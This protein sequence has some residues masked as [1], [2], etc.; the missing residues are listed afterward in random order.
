MFFIFLSLISLSSFGLS[1]KSNDIILSKNIKNQSARK[2]HETFEKLEKTHSNSTPTLWRLKFQKSLFLKKKEQKTFCKN[3]KELSKIESFPLHQLALIQSYEV[4]PYLKTTLVFNVNAFP[5]WLRIRLSEA[6]YERGKT[7]K[8]SDYIFQSAKYLGQGASH[9]DLRIFYLKHA[10]SLSKQK[11][12]PREVAILKNLL[13]KE[14]PYL[15]PKPEFKNYLS[16]AHGYRKN[17]GFNKAQIFYKKILNSNQANFNQKNQS[18]K[19][20]HW[21]YKNRKNYKKQITTSKQWSNWLL[22]ENTVTSLKYYYNNEMNLAREYWNFNE[23]KKALKTIDKI[24]G[25]PKS[26]VV[27]D[28]AYWLKG[29]INE[30]EKNL[31]ESLKNWNTSIK[32]LKK[33]N[34]NQNLL[35]SIL[36]KKAWLLRTQKKYI[37]SLKILHQLRKTTLNPY[38]RFKILFW[39]GE[40]YKDLKYSFLAN[41]SFKKLIEED[42]FGYY[43]LM[44]Y[45]R[46]NNHLNLKI[47]KTD[48]KNHKGSINYN[49]ENIV[50]WL[51]LF[52]ESR[53]LSR[54][55]DLKKDSLLISNKK[56]KE[57]W[58]NLFY[59]YTMSKKYLETFQSLEK[60]S[61][62]IKKYF[63]KNH[64]DL[65]F[66]LEYKDEIEKNAK[67]F[68][69]PK[70]LIYALI[71]QESVFN[72]RA[73]STSDAFGLMQIIP[74][75]ARQT[76]SRLGLTYRGFRQLYNPTRN[77]LLGTAHLKSLLKQY[78][79][80]FILS[81]AAY[82]AG[83]TPV[84]HWQ[85]YITYNSPLEFIENIPYEETRT[86]VRLLIRNYIFYNNLLEYKDSKYPTWIF[87]FDSLSKDKK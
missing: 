74:S 60:M 12:E 45:Y 36:W 66:P 10:I 69:V 63:A 68:D 35:E 13:Y 37:E 7:F 59:L 21:I 51:L 8:N 53:L 27:A 23:N 76:S 50:H 61:P 67:K 73:R 47:S 75:T 40:T 79:N 54:F 32:I 87:K 77:I 41:R 58:I 31:K 81:L 64:V 22:K 48:F 16:I 14:A 3:M 83:A 82:N 85:K 46:L 84:N 72:T 9:K 56:I 17:R 44:A 71:R 34:D 24:M 55:L 33:E 25:D 30:Q 1:L 52:N 86:Y 26:S 11:K 20:L 78:N 49:S 39:I 57:A 29:L 65:L 15:N 42:V 43:G 70:P 2:I 19:W 38:T 62:K 4:C 6:F 5:E 28:Q 80:N 18:F